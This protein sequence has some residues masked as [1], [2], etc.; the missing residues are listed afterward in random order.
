VINTSRGGILD[1]SALV[2]ALES[3]SI[4]GAALDVYTTEPYE[5]ID[6]K[7]DLRKHSNV[8]LTPHAGTTTREA[9]RRMAERC[10]ENIRF[11]ER[12]EYSKMDLVAGPL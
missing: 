9:S 8:I 3:G 5:P 1:E 2:Q 6:K 4:S 12:K 7:H 11:A 10:L